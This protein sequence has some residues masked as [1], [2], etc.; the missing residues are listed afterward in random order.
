M[1]NGHLPFEIIC[2]FAARLIELS[3]TLS[4]LTGHETHE[5]QAFEYSWVTFFH[6]GS[7]MRHAKIPDTDE[8]LT[9]LLTMPRLPN[10]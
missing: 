5:I 9:S 2:H 4:I 8:N 3:S 1:D 7:F 10:G 6:V